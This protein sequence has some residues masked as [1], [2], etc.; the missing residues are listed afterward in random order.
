MATL[1]L[2]LNS[3]LGRM[4]SGERRLAQR[5]TDKLEDDYLCWYDVPVGSKVLYPDFVILHPRRGL[6][7]LEV[8]DWRLDSIKSIDKHFALLITPNGMKE[9]RNPLLQAHVL[10]FPLF[11]RYS[12]AYYY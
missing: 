12:I 4:T 6:L 1:I 7:V 10:L 3:C 11:N 9:V 8:K 2:A 5:L